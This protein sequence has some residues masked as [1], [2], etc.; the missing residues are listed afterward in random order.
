VTSMS[1]IK[2]PTP[3]GLDCKS[4]QISMTVQSGSLQK[5]LV[6]AAVVRKNLR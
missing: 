6:A 4:V 5:T 1:F 3:D 2:T